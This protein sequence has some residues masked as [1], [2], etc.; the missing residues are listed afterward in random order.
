M[1]V[2]FS[3]L[4]KIAGITILLTLLWAASV[5]FTYWDTHRRHIA[6][7]TVLI[8]LALVV[9]LPLIGFLVYIFI[10]ILTRVFSGGVKETDLKT[11]RETALKPPQPKRSPLPTFIASDL[12]MQT[13]LDPKQANPVQAER[14][15]TTAKYLFRIISGQEQGKEFIV[16]RFP[17]RIG[18]GSEAAIRLDEDIGVSRKHAEIYTQGGVLRIRDLD[19]THG[20]QVNGLRIEDNRLEPG[21]QVQ[22][23]LTVLVV[24]AI[25]E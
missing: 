9:L 1:P 8:W 16:E 5:A 13:V 18:R 21:D 12:T 19:S 10:R 3:E 11:R 23:G 17:A 7:G 24:K 6:S 22:I 2:Q 14:Q 4:V 20:T 25:E 15:R